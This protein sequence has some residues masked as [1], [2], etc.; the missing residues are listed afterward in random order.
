MPRSWSENI[1]A[2]TFHE[3]DFLGAT[4]RLLRRTH[5]GF[6]ENRGDGGRF[7]SGHGGTHQRCFGIHVEYRFLYQPRRDGCAFEVIS[8]HMG[9]SHAVRCRDGAFV[10]L[11]LSSASTGRGLTSG[12]GGQVKCGVRDRFCRRP[13]A[14]ENR[15]ATIGGRFAR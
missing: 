2:T 12:S 8:P 4:V 15:L 6:S 10:A 1:M 3:L 7:E 11:L 13:A 5:G 14:R 9:F